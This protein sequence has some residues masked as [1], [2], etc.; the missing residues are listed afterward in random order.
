VITVQ[1]ERTTGRARETW[2]VAAA[3]GVRCARLRREINFLL[4][5]ETAP[6]FSV[7]PVHIYKYAFTVY[8]YH[9]SATCQMNLLYSTLLTQFFSIAFNMYI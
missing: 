8:V 6:F 2:T 7:C 3:D 1:R 9:T 4:T 5:F